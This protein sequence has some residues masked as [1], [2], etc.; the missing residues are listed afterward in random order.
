MRQV[1]DGLGVEMAPLPRTVQRQRLIYTSSDADLD[2]VGIAAFGRPLEHLGG[3]PAFV[4]W[5][6]RLP[7][8]NHLVELLSFLLPLRR[9]TTRL[10]LWSR[11]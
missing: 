10:A 5:I 11:S 1:A 8:A 3:F 2:A 4:G 7:G 9:L 6:V